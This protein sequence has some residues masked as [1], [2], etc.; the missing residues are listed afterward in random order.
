[1]KKKV[2]IIIIILSFSLILFDV[3]D[4]YILRN[5]Y[6]NNFKEVEEVEVLKK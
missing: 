2:L 1:M 6:F 3:Y 4:K 5:V